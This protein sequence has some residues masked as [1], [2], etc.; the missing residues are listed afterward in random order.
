MTSL[1]WA[2][3]LIASA[4]PA[5][6]PPLAAW[7]GSW[8]GTGEAF[9]RPATATLEIGPAPGG[10]AMR[11]AYSLSINGAPSA[12]YAAA[13]I[14][15]VDGGGRLRGSW[16][17]SHGRTRPV[18]GRVT[19]SG[20]TANW[21][22]ADAE[23]GRSTYRLETPDRLVVIDSVLQDDGGWRGFATL[24]YRRNKR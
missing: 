4:A 24:H 19:P 13:A 6:T 17:D 1:W 11:L 16:T 18:A 5:E 21:G 15:R 12:A 23:I 22:S 10:G 20:W 7:Y 14:Y 9:G 8:T 2:A 3:A